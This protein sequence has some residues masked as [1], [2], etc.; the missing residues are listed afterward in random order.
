VTTP[1]T[2][3]PDRGAEFL[4]KLLT[5]DPDHLDV[6]SDEE[7]ERQ[8]DAAGIQ[9]KS[10]PTADELFA[11]AEKRAAAR[12]PASGLRPVHVPAPAPKSRI[13]RM[14]P[15][16]LAAAVAAVAI[17]AVTL[18]NHEAIVAYL[19]GEPVGPSVAASPAQRAASLRDEAFAACDAQRWEECT[20]KLDEAKALDPEGESEPRVVAARKAVDDA[21]KGPRP[22][23]RGIFQER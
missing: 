12:A 10:V 17:G 21:P 5:D 11:R 22:H 6:A 13:R 9:V 4:R 7:I 14:S 3:D 1:R 15:A 23:R 19:R 2:P 20:R 18:L 16:S 8:M